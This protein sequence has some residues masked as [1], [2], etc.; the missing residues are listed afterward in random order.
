MHSV[1]GCKRTPLVEVTWP[2]YSGSS[3]NRHEGSVPEF[4]S[5]ALFSRPFK[6]ETL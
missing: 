4:S 6:G 3:C 1:S 5:D 2:S